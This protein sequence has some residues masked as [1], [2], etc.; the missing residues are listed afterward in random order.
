MSTTNGSLD[1]RTL[2]VVPVPAVALARWVLLC[3]VACGGVWP[4]AAG[5]VGARFGVVQRLD[6]RDGLSQASCNCLF[7]DSVGFIW[8]GTQ[9]GLNRWDGYGFQVFRRSGTD[10]ASL[11]DN[12]V[13]TIVENP[14]GVLW[15]GTRNGLCRYDINTGRFLRVPFPKREDDAAGNARILALLADGP[16]VWI[17][18]RDKGLY[19]LDAT[20]N[21][22]V[23]MD[24]VCRNP[25]HFNVQSIAKD[26]RGNIWIGTMGGLI[27]TDSRG[28]LVRYWGKASFLAMSE[29]TLNIQSLCAVG[30]RTL[31]IGTLDGLCRLDTVSYTATWFRPEADNPASVSD[32][33]ITSIICT[34]D[35]ALW[36]A[37]RAGGLNRLASGSNTFLRFQNDPED[38]TSLG[39]NR[40]QALLEDAGGLLWVGCWSGGINKLVM[41]PFEYHCYQSDPRKGLG[42]RNVRSILESASG[43]VWIG[44][45]EDGLDCL[46]PATGLFRHFRHQPGDPGS[47]A[48]DKNL[49]SLAEGRDG[50]IYVALEQGGLNRLNPATGV[51][52]HYRHDPARYDSLS[53]NTTRC[54]RFD[55]HGILWIGTEND[56]NSFN[57]STGE[58]KRY[59]LT[60]EERGK[61]VPN[62]V[63]YI[64]ID[65]NGWL[66]C[67]LYDSGVSVL[68]PNFGVR[69]RFRNDDNNQNG[70]ANNHVTA[71]YEDRQGNVWLGTWGGG[72]QYIDA[73]S[74]RAGKPRFH[75]VGE[76]EGIHATSISAV[77]EDH[78]GRLW[79]SSS[80]GVFRR[81]L[82]T[83]KF[84]FF[85]S[86]DGLPDCNFNPRSFYL[87]RSG[88][89]MLGGLEGLTILNPSQFRKNTHV[90]PIVLT[91]FSKFNRPYDLPVP[92]NAAKELTLS[93]GDT[94]F[95]FTFSAL[96]YS[97]PEKNQYAYKLEGFNDEWIQ[98]SASN[99]M[100]TFTNLGPGTYVLRVKGSNDQGVWNEAGHALT[101]VIL[102]P[103]YRTWYAYLGMAFV[104]L[105]LL[106]L[107][108]RYRNMRHRQELAIHR[109]ELEYQKLKAEWLQKIDKLKDDFIANTSH[110]LRTPLTS[111]IGYASIIRKKFNEA[112]FNPEETNG[113]DRQKTAEQIRE[114]LDILLSESRRL[115]ILIEDLLDLNALENQSVEW[116]IQEVDLR[117]LAREVAVELEESA[118]AKGL[119][120]EVALPVDLPMVLGDRRR[121]R[122]VVWNL[123]SNAV[124]FSPAGVIEIRIEAVLP[125]G[126]AEPRAE[127]TEVLVSVMDNGLGLQ[128]ADCRTVFERFR[129]VGDTLTAKPKGAG[130]GLPICKRIIEHHR[131]RIWAEC[132]PM[133]GAIFRFVLP[134]RAAAEKKLT[135]S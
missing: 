134:V 127:G 122:Q 4:V 76:N 27:R 56:L 59:S 106:T 65:R 132:N 58:V 114:N 90:P 29:K 50:S 40:V 73:V 36:V 94:L 99:R 3:L 82:Q 83:G 104:G 26:A 98:T 77:L 95:S 28:R 69:W 52:T 87:S 108:V 33:N 66:W 102:P 89:I 53:S 113:K 45:T 14:N 41:V 86:G 68:D 11:P 135:A 81:D 49:E 112:V 129:Q 71:I 78:Q 30:D 107:L 111:V 6:L 105:F 60:P 92:I 31:W 101:I 8:A 20:T 43:K 74:L 47:L 63:D 88:K 119:E 109:A 121:L 38:Q 39:G 13:Q 37:T 72:L 115:M 75:V 2:R 7:Q 55:A 64:M 116:E 22:V 125:E 133:G 18:T 67:S 24:G 130:L 9:D 62:R 61:P 15:L 48:S 5:P 10:V 118:K 128:D 51:F 54:L 126:K 46:D 117:Q 12:W 124:K 103:W 123:V 70:L 32:A 19:R 35:G 42:G 57:P 34:R 91:G 96:D 110:E 100:A 97:T 80:I 79:I 25:G 44:T 17:G 1:S 16:T 85:D 93:H 131:G 23:R 120:L 84:Q 21:E